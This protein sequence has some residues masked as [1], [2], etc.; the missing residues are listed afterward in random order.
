MPFI[1]LCAYRIASGVLPAI[2][3]DADILYGIWYGRNSQEIKVKSCM[4]WCSENSNIEEN[5]GQLSV[6]GTTQTRLPL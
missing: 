2:T 1:Q 4:R 6:R 3:Y 5:T